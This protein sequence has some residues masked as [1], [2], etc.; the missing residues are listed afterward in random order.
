MRDPDLHNFRL[1]ILISGDTDTVSG[2]LVGP[3]HC[4]WLQYQVRPSPGYGS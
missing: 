2:S 1:Q 4:R 3:R